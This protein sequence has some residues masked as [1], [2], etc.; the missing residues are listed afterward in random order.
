MYSSLHTHTHTHSIDTGRGVF[1]SA[2]SSDLFA[3]KCWQ[4]FGLMLVSLWKWLSPRTL[5][6]VYTIRRYTDTLSTNIKCSLFINIVNYMINI[7]WIILPDCSYVLHDSLFEE[8]FHLEHVLVFLQHFKNG[9][10]R[11]AVKCQLHSLDRLDFLLGHLKRDPFLQFQ[12]EM[13]A[14]YCKLI[15]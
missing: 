8:K 7:L 2:S 5:D 3:W 6:S 1:N 14:N 13:K 9:Q 11:N 4:G 12:I 10:R 15:K